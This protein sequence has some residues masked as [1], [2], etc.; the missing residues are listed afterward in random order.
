MNHADKPTKATPESTRAPDQ[1]TVSLPTTP[2]SQGV[3]IL[4]LAL[5]AWCVL[6]ALG[7]FQTQASTD[8]RRPLIMVLTMGTFLGIWALALHS[9]RARQL[10]NQ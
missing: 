2:K 3:S 8:V 5:I 4:F 10:R 7:L 1:S 9:K 6:I